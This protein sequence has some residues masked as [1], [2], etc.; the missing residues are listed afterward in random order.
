MCDRLPEG[1]ANGQPAPGA[2][3]NSC[4]RKHRETNAGGPTDDTTSEERHQEHA[5]EREGEPADEGADE[6]ELAENI[7]YELRLRH[8]SN[9]LQLKTGGLTPGIAR[10]LAD[11]DECPGRRHEAYREA[12]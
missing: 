11:S 4:R 10:S 2:G 7:G 3:D 5:D 6:S 1:D 9:Q 8:D 12:T